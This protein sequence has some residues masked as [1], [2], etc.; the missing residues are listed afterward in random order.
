MFSE[1]IQDFTGFVVDCSQKLIGDI[2]KQNFIKS[3]SVVE[4]EKNVAVKKIRTEVVDV[5]EKKI[6]K[7]PKA[8]TNPFDTTEEEEVEVE[9]TV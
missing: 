8:K 3:V 5:V 1:L 4:E 7:R 6:V 2:H 9:E